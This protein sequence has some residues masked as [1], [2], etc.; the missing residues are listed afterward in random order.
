MPNLRGP[1]GAIVSAVRIE[2]PGDAD[3]SLIA[4]PWGVV[5]PRR[6]GDN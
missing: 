5:E 2:P 4:P 1:N 6:E 3:V